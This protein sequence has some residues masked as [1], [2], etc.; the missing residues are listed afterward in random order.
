[1]KQSRGTRENTRVIQDSWLRCEEF[2]L[3]HNSKPELV[4]LTRS[5]HVNQKD[6]FKNLIDTT[7]NEVL[8]YYEN[9]LSNSHCLIML[10]NH[11][12][13]ILDSWGDRRFLDQSNRA[14]FSGGGVAP[15][16][17]KIPGPMPLVLHCS[18]GTRSRSTGTN[19]FSKPIVLWWGQQLLFS[20]LTGKWLVFSI[21]HQTV[22]FPR[23]TLWDW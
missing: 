12:G 16:R 13:Q 19:T 2:G 11:Q 4:R 6:R 22:T 14:F 9:I 1:M 8:P 15:C 23:R 21:F 5:D 20:M 17:K 7:G 18:V 10:S 3:T